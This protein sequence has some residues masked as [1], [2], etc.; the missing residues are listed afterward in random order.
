MPPSCGLPEQVDIIIII[1]IIIITISSWTT[2]SSTS[3]TR[4]ARA[5]RASHRPSST[6]LPSTPAPAAATGQRFFTRIFDSFYPSSSHIYLIQLVPSSPHVIIS[7]HPDTSTPS[8]PWSAAARYITVNYN[9]GVH[10]QFYSLQFL[11]VPG[12]SISS[13]RSDLDQNLRIRRELD[14]R[15]RTSR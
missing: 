11:T 8:T 10:N 5:C 13:F 6:Q 1:I 2:S 14:I 15:W 12:P 3:L 9:T 4:A 7:L